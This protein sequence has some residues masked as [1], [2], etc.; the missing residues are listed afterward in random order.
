PP[1]QGTPDGSSGAAA[2]ARATSWDLLGASEATG[3]IVRMDVPGPVRRLA[4]ILAADMVGFSR[5][6]KTTGDDMLEDHWRRHAGRVSW[7]RRCGAVRSRGP[8]QAEKVR[9]A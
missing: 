1:R 9:L 5:L 2:A 4:A 6:I 7:R 8:M 3:Q